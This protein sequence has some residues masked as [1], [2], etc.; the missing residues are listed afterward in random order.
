M[1][2][3]VKERAHDEAVTF[4]LVKPVKQDDVGKALNVLEADSILW[5]YLDCALDLRKGGLNGR[6][7]GFM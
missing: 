6:L 7:A 1:L 2:L 4:A 5:V 3:L